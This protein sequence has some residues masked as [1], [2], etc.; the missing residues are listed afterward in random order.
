M[1]RLG[2]PHHIPAAVFCDPEVASVGLSVEELERRWP[3]DARLHLR[4]DLA[5]TDRGLTDA[6]THGAVIVDAERLTGKLLR[7]TIVGPAASEAIGIF[8][9]AFDR[10]LSLHRLFAMVHPYPTY[11]SAI[12]AVTDE[13]SRQTLPHLKAEAAAYLRHVPTRLRR[14]LP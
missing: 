12:G 6:V 9:L 4:V 5:D 8:T 2:K 13:F 3:A 14:L 7:A 11:A 10:G 1:L